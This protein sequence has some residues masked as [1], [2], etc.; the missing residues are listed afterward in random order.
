MHAHDLQTALAAASQALAAGG[1]RQLAAME[2]EDPDVSAVAVEVDRD[3]A[4]TVT[5]TN[6]DGVPV[7]G[8]TL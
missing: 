4:M 1:V 5:L 8:Y 2:F 6:A 7:G 3:G